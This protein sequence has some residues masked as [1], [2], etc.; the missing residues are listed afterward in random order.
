MDIQRLRAEI[1]A[2]R[3]QVPAEQVAE[4]IIAWINPTIL[5]RGTQENA[6]WRPTPPYERLWR[7]L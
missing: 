4:A 1:E 7:T 3:Y 6:A 2:G 5:E